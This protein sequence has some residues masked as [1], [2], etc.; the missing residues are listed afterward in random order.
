M[1]TC[2]EYTIPFCRTE[3]TGHRHKAPDADL[4]LLQPHGSALDGIPTLAI[5]V[6]FSEGLADLRGDAKR[7]LRGANGG[8]AAVVLIKFI[9]ADRRD[10][11][12]DSW[13]EVWKLNVRQ[14]PYISVRKVS[15]QIP[16]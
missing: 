13:V 7:L 16:N 12:A 11:P 10:L 4:V 6:G 3:P 5:E 8:I 9:F 1:A 14:D 15:A 2:G